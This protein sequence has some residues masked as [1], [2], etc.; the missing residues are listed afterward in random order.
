MDSLTRAIFLNTDR[1]ADLV[2]TLK[3][4]HNIDP[5]PE[6]TF[7]FYGPDNVDIDYPGVLKSYG[8]DP[9]KFE[10]VPDWKL[11]HDQPQGCPA[12]IDIYR[13]GGWIAQQLIKL[14]ALEHLFESFDVVLIQ[15]CDTF[16]VKPYNW[17]TCDSVLQMY[18][19]PKTSHTEDYYR[20]VKIF[21][22]QSR[23]T[24]YCFVTEFMPVK[25]TSWQLLKTQLE[26]PGQNW[27]QH[28]DAV[29]QNEKVPEPNWL[30]RLNPWLQNKKG[31][32]QN[33][34][35]FSEYE[36]LGNWNLFVDKNVRILPQKRFELQK[37]WQENLDKLKH[38]DAV[39]NYGS[40]AL[41][42]VDHWANNFM[43]HS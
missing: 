18:G 15:D 34:V 30:H 14:I 25:K 11:W 9:D 17:I 26:Q 43:R 41:D 39:A 8:I 35:W 23:L 40:I 20:F 38:C 22:G 27:L 2:L 19:L 3:F 33:W 1:L 24:D 13:Y 28:M 21:T 32:V 5:L 10:F 29:F 31:F 37:K 42:D 16:N 7:V 6:K 12:G 4:D 36:L